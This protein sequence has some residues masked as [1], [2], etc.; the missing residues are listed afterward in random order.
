[1]TLSGV[2]EGLEIL[3]RYYA[4]DG[5]HLSADHDVIYASATDKIL[6]EADL[7]RMV[8]LGWHQ[9]IDEDVDFSPRFYRQDEAWRCF[10]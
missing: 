4:G 6:S 1:M 5:Y 2:R 8:Q 10:V 9:E 7:D 3:S